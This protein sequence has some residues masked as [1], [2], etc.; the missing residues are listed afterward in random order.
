MPIDRREALTIIASG[1]AAALGLPTRHAAAAPSRFYI[2]TN[3]RPQGGY[4]AAG[5]TANGAKLFET[6][7]PGRGHGVAASPQGDRAVVL[8][9]RPGTFGIAV[10]TADGAVQAQLRTPAGFHFYGHGAFSRDGRLL[11]TTE[12]DFDR[13]RGAIGVWDA[14][15]GYRRTAVLP[16]HGIGP[17]EVILADDGKTLI[18]ANGGIRTHPASGREKLNI[19]TMSPSLAYVE[20][21]DGRLLNRV[22]FDKARHR[23]LSLRHIA[24][25]A[26]GIVCAGLQD[27]RPQGDDVPLVV[28]HRRGE[29]RRAFGIAPAHIWQRM[30]SYTG[31]VAF[32]SSGAVAAVSAPRGNMVTFWD[33]ASGQYRCHASLDDVCGV[34]ASGTGGSFV[35][36]S[37]AGGIWR[38]DIRSQRLSAMRTAFAAERPWDNH[39]VATAGL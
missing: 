26:Q 4:E 34:A 30:R 13:G 1:G 6:A 21:K 11:Y 33:A 38:F 14:E 19:D 20:A 24:A 37:G 18:V 17:H 15:N 2:G 22:G 7:L 5:F 31:S 23:T 35:L 9:R 10:E 39:L 25:N 12:N 8:A 16:S 28:F 32:D 27:Q 29:N 3:V 36:T